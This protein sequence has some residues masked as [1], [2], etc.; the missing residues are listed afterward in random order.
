M[1]KMERFDYDGFWKDLLKRFFEPFLH[2]ALPELHAA[3]RLDREPRFL[4][5]ELRSSGISSRP[6]RGTFTILPPSWTTSSTSL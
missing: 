2:L 3:A 6:P 5:A 1:A 4:E